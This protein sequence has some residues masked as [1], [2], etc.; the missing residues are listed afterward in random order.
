M[1]IEVQGRF[2]NG[3]GFWFFTFHFGSNSHWCENLIE[4]SLKTELSLALAG[5]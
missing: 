1:K 2:F 5:Q 4:M 3:S